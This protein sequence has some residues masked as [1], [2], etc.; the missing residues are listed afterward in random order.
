[1]IQR[2]Q[3]IYLFISGMSLSALFLAFMDFAGLKPEA[4]AQRTLALSDGVINLEDNNIAMIC[5]FAAIAMFIAAIFL[6][7]NR[8][9]QMKVVAVSMIL[10]MVVFLIAVWL[11]MTYMKLA[12]N[13]LLPGPGL[14][15]PVLAIIFGWLS[16]RS[17]RKDE[18]LVKSMDRLR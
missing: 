6:Y 3:S 14:V 8:S 17:I 10:T 11:L 5:T 15:S 12:G 7:R 9:L 18:A 13:D 4:E 2:I 16:N 1:M